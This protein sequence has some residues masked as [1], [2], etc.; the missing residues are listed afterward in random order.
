VACSPDGVATNTTGLVHGPHS[1]FFRSLISNHLRP[2]V[3][4][5]LSAQNVMAS[6]LVPSSEQN[7]NVGF[8]VGFVEGGVSLAEGVH[9]LMKFQQPDYILYRLANDQFA[10]ERK[11]IAATAKAMKPLLDFWLEVKGKQVDALLL[12]TKGDFDDAVSVLSSAEQLKVLFCKEL[13]AYLEQLDAQATPY[14]RG[15][16]HGRVAFEAA[17][18]LVGEIKLLEAGQITKITKVGFLEKLSAKLD[19]LSITRGEKAVAAVEE[20]IAFSK[21]PV[22]SFGVS[23]TT[24]YQARFFNA[25]PELQG[26]VVVH[27][28]VEQQT[29][30]RFPGVVTTSEMHSLENLRG[31]PNHLNPQVHLSQIRKE[32]NRF[33]RA[34][35]TP[36]KQQLLDKATEI[37]DQFG[38]LFVPPIR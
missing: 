35:P 38:H 34:T 30:T 19:G 28:A 22:A 23:T 27:H 3:M 13:I 18:L 16:L 8:G 21:R 31:I 2:A 29:L 17:T 1:S 26:K 15:K 10:E 25:F 6:A 14:E 33:Y 24:D 32:W 37:D 12:A 20:A 11:S 7:F 4:L 5:A 36:T 9:T